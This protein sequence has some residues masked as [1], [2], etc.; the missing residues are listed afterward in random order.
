MPTQSGP[1]WRPAGAL[2]GRWNYGLGLAGLLTIASGY[3]ALAQRPHDSF[4]SLTLAPLLLVLGELI[5]RAQQQWSAADTPSGAGR[6]AR[7]GGVAVGA[8]AL[9]FSDAQWANR[10]TLARRVHV[11]Q[12]RRQFLGPSSGDDEVAAWLGRTIVGGAGPR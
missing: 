7:W 9:A 10:A 2:L 6:I 1:A 4:L 5:Q 11:L 12:A 3:V 8:L